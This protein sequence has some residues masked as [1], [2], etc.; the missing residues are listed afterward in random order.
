MLRTHH[1]HTLTAL[2]LSSDKD[3]GQD[4]E[5][6]YTA[7]KYARRELESQ[8]HSDSARRQAK[9]NLASRP[10]RLLRP[11]CH[12][13]SAL[14]QERGLR[15]GGFVHAVTASPGGMCHPKLE[16]VCSSQYRL[17]LESATSTRSRATDWF[18][19]I[20]QEP[21]MPFDEHAF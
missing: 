14:V 17:H 1:A 10:M 6:P 12:R 15:H 21:R 9:R 3:T 7:A 4:S 20:F 11:K 5:V 16:R 2:S 19:R 18:H 8:Q 13:I